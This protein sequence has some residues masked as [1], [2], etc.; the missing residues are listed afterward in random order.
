MNENILFLL[1]KILEHFKHFWLCL[2]DFGLHKNV[3]LLPK[4]NSGKTFNDF[5]FLSKFIELIETF[6]L[7]NKSG[8][9]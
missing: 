2:K 3:P 4:K 5:G 9:H 7:I 1:Q 8:T 6:H